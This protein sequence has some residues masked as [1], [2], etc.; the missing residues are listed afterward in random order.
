MMTLIKNGLVYDG[1]G[2][3]PVKRDLLVQGDLIVRIGNLPKV[4]AERTIDAA[5]R[6]V[7]PGFI[8][9]DTYSDAS[10]TLFSDPLQEDFLAQGVTTIVGGNSGESL[11]PYAR[12]ETSFTAKWAASSQNRNWRSVR[13]LFGALRGRGFGANFGTL[14]GLATLRRALVG[15]ETRDMTRAELAAACA[16]L[17]EGLRAGALGLSADLSHPN[18]RPVPRHE[19]LAFMG[20]VARAKGVFVARVRDPQENVEDSVREI[21]RLAEETGAN[22]ELS[23]LVPREGF[24]RHYEAALAVVEGHRG[25]VRVGFDTAPFSERIVLVTDLLPA[26]AREDDV[27]A[28]AATLAFPNA[29]KRIL[30]FVRRFPPERVRVFSVPESV[31]FLEGRTMARLAE[32]FGMSPE[33]AV[34]KVM[35]L[36]RME[37]MCLVGDVCADVADAFLRSPSSVLSLGGGSGRR[38]ARSPKSRPVFPPSLVA[39]AV[40]DGRMPLEEAVRKFASAPAERYGLDRRGSLREGS[41]ADIAVLDGSA[42]SHVFVNGSLAFENGT[43]TGRR[44][45][46]AVARRR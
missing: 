25:A 42:P 36:S 12:H 29:R 11:A 38:P 19:L 9:V 24:A 39:A 27:R 35:E 8:D 23:N 28:L 37:A 34:L 22:A 3:P 45:G 43:P 17:S 18:Q 2:G 33:E 20:V 44:A 26:W 13:E 4:R 31:R 14:I 1:S 15:P 30:A 10:G 16:M 41:Y 46:R 5:G 40:A 32:S 21:V 7:V 6:A